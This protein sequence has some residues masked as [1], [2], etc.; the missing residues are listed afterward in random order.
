MVLVVVAGAAF[1]VGL[2]V[3]LVIIRVLGVL[4]VLKLLMFL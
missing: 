3:A 2:V 1:V 4:V